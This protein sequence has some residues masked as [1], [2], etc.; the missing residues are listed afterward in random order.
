MCYVRWE[1]AEDCWRWE[2]AIVPLSSVDW[3]IGDL[4]M[5]LTVIRLPPK[6]YT[7][8]GIDFLSKPDEGLLLKVSEI[9]P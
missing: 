8:K 2:L 5:W 9:T 1:V 4:V 7:Y 6:C 3:W